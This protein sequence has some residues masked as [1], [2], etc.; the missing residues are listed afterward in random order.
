MRWSLDELYS[1]FSSDEYQK[2]LANLKELIGKFNKWGDE[3]L[4]KR[5]QARQKLEGYIEFSKEISTSLTKLMTFAMLTS[6][7]DVNNEEALMYSDQLSV[8][9]TELTKPQVS[10]QKFIKDLDGLDDIIASSEILTEHEFFLMEIKKA[11]KYMLSEKEEVLISKMRNTGS[12]AWTNLQNKI[13]SNLLVDIVLDGEKKSLPLPVVRNMAYHK[14]AHVRKTA[15]EAELES[16]K[17]VE[18]ASAA[19]LNGIKGEVITLADL[20][21]Y[22]PLE[23]V[24]LQSRMDR[25]TLDAMF[26]AIMEY[27]PVFHKYYR[28]K[29]KILGHKN[30]LPFYDM[31]APVGSLDLT[32][33]YDEAMEFVVE[34]FRTFSDR[35]ADYAQ[36]AYENNWLDVE[37]REGKRGGAFCSNIHPIG[38]SRIMANFEGSFSNMTTLAH[39]LGHGYHGLNLKDESILNSRYPMPI[40]ETA[41]IFCETIVE[42][43]QLEKST[44]EEVLGILES[45]ISGAGQVIVD[46]FSRY[47]FETRLFEIRKDHPL[48]VDELKNLMVEAQK[49]AYGDGLDHDYLHPYMWINKG[50]YYSAGRNF[51]NFPYAFGLLFAK[52]I[53]AEY[54]NRGKDFVP[55]YDKLLNATGKNSIKDVAAMVGI[56]VSNP[57]FFR[58]SLKLIEKDI[59]RFIEISER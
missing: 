6:S 27:L 50:H 33:T 22:S 26:T 13:A 36:N 47:L 40:A 14:D 23:E 32:F 4:D 5:D 18:E 17:K 51:Y 24:L 3:N 12:R 34:N 16:Y 46:I 29:G 20:R 11:S 8:L 59:E 49:E 15:Y 35:L 48:S 44:D 43:A 25:E 10:F 28:Q 42:N 38:E 45:S 58:N 55:E 7:V 57:D 53:Y 54:L 31:F 2:D 9:A 19:A 21:G 41:S 30:G 52:G 39:E 37:P 1:G 56:D